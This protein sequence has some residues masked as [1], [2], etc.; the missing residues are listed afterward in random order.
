MLYLQSAVVI[1][2]NATKFI[3]QCRSYAPLSLVE[4]KQFMSITLHPVAAGD[5]FFEGAQCEAC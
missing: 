2:M 5:L 4:H 3:T 1:K